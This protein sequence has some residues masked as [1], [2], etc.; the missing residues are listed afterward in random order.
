MLRE[1]REAGRA[2][3][4]PLLLP[5]M[6]PAAD[7]RCL[8]MFTAAMM[9]PLIFSPFSRHAADAMITRQI[10]MLRHMLC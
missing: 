2:S 9:S 1:R 5:R 7:A 6:L 8:E 4:M 10:S 3:L